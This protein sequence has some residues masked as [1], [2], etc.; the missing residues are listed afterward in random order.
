MLEIG[1]QHHQQGKCNNI[2]TRIEQE[3]GKV[4][5]NEKGNS[6][7]TSQDNINKNE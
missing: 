2:N 7:K 5:T 4:P 1:S 3:M 6:K